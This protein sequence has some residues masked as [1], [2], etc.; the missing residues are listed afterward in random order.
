MAKASFEIFYEDVLAT[1]HRQRMENDLNFSE[2]IGALEMIKHDILNEALED[3][4]DERT[5]YQ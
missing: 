5:G 3:R 1:I 4:V 2:M